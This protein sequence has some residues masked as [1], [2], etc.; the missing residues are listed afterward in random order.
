MI[1]GPATTSESPGEGREPESADAQSH[2][3]LGEGPGSL[4]ETMPNGTNTLAFPTETILEVTLQ[5]PSLSF[6]LSLF[7]L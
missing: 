7:F 1:D 2:W 5:L 6:F 4:E 3:A